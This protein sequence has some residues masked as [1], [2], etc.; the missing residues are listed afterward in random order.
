[1]PPQPIERRPSPIDAP[2]TPEREAVIAEQNPNIP[3]RNSQAD[4][5]DILDAARSRVLPPQPER[6]LQP[7]RPSQP[8]RAPE[9]A[10][11]PA[12]PPPRTVP[13]AP[14]LVQDA[15]AE[16]H[17]EPVPEIAPPRKP[18]SDFESILESEMSNTLTAERV[19]HPASPAAELRPMPEPVVSP[20][21]R[22]P[23]MATITGGDAALQK[24]VARI[25]GEI[26]VDRDK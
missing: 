14:I 17:D 6:P 10:A 13:L 4:V 23:D 5:A 7:E 3:E 20:P 1:V 16:T 22:D 26:S 24:E 8:E 18:G 12:A 21:R 19:V 2:T 25:F 9:V 11:A 15:Y